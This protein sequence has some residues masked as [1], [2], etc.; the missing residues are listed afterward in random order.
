MPAF[1]SSP[2]L[3]CLAA[4]AAGVLTT[5]SA[6]PFMLWWLAPVAAGLLYAGLPA[7]S[8]RQAA[9]R[10]WCYGLGLFGTGVSWVYVSIHDYGYTGVPLAVFLT[11]L[12]VATLALF[13]AVTLW[14]YRRLAGPR[15]A[16]LTFA[17]AW[18]LGEALRTWLFT[19]FPWLLLGS[20]QVDSPLAPWAPVGGVYLLSLITALSGALGVELL[21]RRWWAALPLAGLWLIPLALPLQ[22]THPAGDPVRVALLQG[23]LSQLIKWTPEGQ[24]TAIDTYRRLT[25]ELGDTPLDLVIWPEA[26]LPMFEDQARPVLE[27]AQASLPD[28]T[29]LLTGILQR[30]EQGN[31]YNSVVGL[32]GVQGEYRKHHLV[33]FGEYLPLESL[34]RGAIAFFDLPM[35]AMTPGPDGQQ[36]MVAAGT[37][38]GNAICYEI[39][40]ADL[41][42]KQARHANVLL[43]LSNDTWFGDSLGPQQHLQMARLRA[44]ENG[45]Y[46]VRATSN[47]VTAIVDPQGRVTGRLPQFE[48]AT[49]VGEYVPM[50]GLT[51]FTRTGS[52]PIWLL[53]ALMVLPGIRLSAA[54]S[55]KP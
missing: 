20:G 10:G 41:V 3:G 49:L 50:E 47:G 38:I 30:D 5:L 16:V 22:W 39:I 2:L 35:P 25:R 15:F 45:R 44:L 31:F 4:L 43:T 51:P 7:L 28:D 55:R 8:P 40:Y 18:V 12:F 48:A 46:V 6:A 33:P 19:G 54:V 32:N 52:W 9:W 26:A 11:T 17:G 29:Q 13:F 21:R 37:R 23:N 53:A 24:R 27:R 36:P 1:R 14:L 42:A 34:L